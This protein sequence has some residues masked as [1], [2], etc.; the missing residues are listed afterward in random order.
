M[1]VVKKK[2]LKT[3]YKLNPVRADIAAAQPAAAPGLGRAPAAADSTTQRRKLGHC[4]QVQSSSL[5]G[6]VVTK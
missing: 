1:K 4:A 6:S 2:K 3:V 5:T